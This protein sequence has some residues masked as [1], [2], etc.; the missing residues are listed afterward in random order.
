MLHGEKIL[1]RPCTKDDA[2]VL[3][4]EQRADVTGFMLSSSAP[5]FPVPLETVLEGW[6]PVDAHHAKPLPKSATFA[7]EHEGELA[8]SIT[9]WGIDYHH[10]NGEIGIG[11]R[12]SFRGKGLSIDALKVLCH[13]AFY[14]LGLHR[15]QLVTGARNVPMQKAA[16]AA[17]FTEEGRH[18]EAWWEGDGFADDVHYGLLDHEWRTLSA[19][20]RVR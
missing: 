1:L 20:Q 2:A 13:Y 10:R 15:V 14:V 3:Y 7:I 17:G 19:Q 11:L 5:W 9:L 4:A 18:R 16:L 6:E 8:G 12:E